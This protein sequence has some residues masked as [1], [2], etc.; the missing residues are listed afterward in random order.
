M[1]KLWQRFDFALIG[2]AAAVAFITITA[3]FRWEL[4]VVEF[5]VAI[6]LF[7]L[8]VVYQKK[9][10]EKLLFRVQAVTESLDFE[11]GK[12]FADLTV[13][14]AFV[15]EDGEILWFNDAFRD[16]F[17][18]TK[19]TPLQNLKTLLKRD[20][21][22]KLL[23]GRGFKIR[24]GD[25]YFA[26]YSSVVEIENEKN[27]LLYFFDETALRLT[28]KEY[29]DSKPSILLAV[30]DNADEL[31]QEFK[32]SECTAV[33]SK[34][35]QMVEDWVTSYGGLCRKFSSDRV[36]IF[37]QE[38]SLQ[39]MIADK[40]SILDAVRAFTYEG[41]GADLTLSVGIGKESNFA[42]S[43]NSARQ[44]LDMAQSRGG[45][46]V[47]IRH[48]AN[49]K[50]YGGVSAGFERKNKSKARLIAKSIRELIA[51]SDHVLIMGHR[52]S[53][54]DA[55]GAAV[56]LSAIAAYFGK[57]VNVVVDRATTLSTPMLKQYE[58]ARGKDVFI[59]PERALAFANERT[60][61]FVVDTHKK[62]FTEAP[63]LLEKGSKVVVIDHHRKSVDYIDNA[64]VFYHLP[65]ASSASEMVTEL[66][67]YMDQKPILDQPAAQALFAGIMLDTRNFVIR[68]GVRTFEAAAYLRSR[69]ANTV[70]AKK[71]FSNDMDVFRHRNQ[72][73]DA[74]TRF[75]EYYAI[76]V[77]H[78]QI[79]NLRLITS[80]AAD[81]MLNIDGV[82]ASFVLFRLGDQVNISARSYGEVNVQIIME[83]LGGG[84]HQT[85]AACQLTGISLEEAL[86]RLQST[87]Q[88]CTKDR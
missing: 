37:V 10:K 4:A 3:F 88:K 87:I 79:P 52:F 24:V 45:D 15:Y 7:A 59:S 13:A 35:E 12:A 62:D 50:F 16:R 78:A 61:L 85:M 60:L 65:S 11:T 23:D 51:E 2:F 9:V 48:E 84:G 36:L 43:Y 71:L 39:R 28:E 49:Y 69:A 74:A 41:K 76:S 64:V 34:L 31:Y 56:G 83:A 80:Q 19:K 8:R 53:D 29:Y 55:V 40:F 25:Q 75:N 86:S 44:A 6:L 47:A 54:Y 30:I 1:K 18:I 5:G 63:A 33:L 27:Y 20:K 72:I 82:K 14:C 26:V 81:E 57:R 42:E 73:I 77:A 46:Q 66:A 67:Q 22:D 32:E 58:S 70:E 38:R 17:S 21:I 68:T